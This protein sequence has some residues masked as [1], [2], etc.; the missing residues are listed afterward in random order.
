LRHRLSVLGVLAAAAAVSGLACGDDEAPSTQ[1]VFWLALS[2][3]QGASCSS[4]Q[5]Y[6]VP[7]TARSTITSTDGVGARVVD[8][9]ADLVQCSVIPSATAGSFDIS[10]R[11]SSGAI[12]NFLASGVLPATGSGQLDV[13]FKTADFSLEQ[14]NCTATIETLNADGALW[15]SN[16]SCTNLRDNNS[17]AIACNG[18]GGVIFENCD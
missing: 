12:G 3:G 9:G 1:A 7:E 16:L 14:D 8:S 6:T 13:N 15:V 11:L 10:L 5:T 4:S 18:T 2:P 17:P